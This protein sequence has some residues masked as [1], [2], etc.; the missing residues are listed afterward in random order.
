MQNPMCPAFHKAGLVEI[1]TVLEPRA[2]N[3]EQRPDD[4]RSIQPGLPPLLLYFE[5]NSTISCS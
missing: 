4:G 2:S 3:L 1:P 5:Y